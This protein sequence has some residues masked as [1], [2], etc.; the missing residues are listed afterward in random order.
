MVVAA[1]TVWGVFCTMYQFTVLAPS[2]DENDTCCPN[3]YDNFASSLIHC[4]DTAGFGSS[5]VFQG[6]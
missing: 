6:F 3:I 1:A 4:F 5:F 2:D